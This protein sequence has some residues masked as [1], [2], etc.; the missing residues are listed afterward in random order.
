MFYAQ[1]GFPPK[2]GP[3]RV[4]SE[5][6]NFDLKNLI[7][8]NFPKKPVET[9]WQRKVDCIYQNYD[10]TSGLILVLLFFFTKLFFHFFQ[11]EIFLNFCIFGPTKWIFLTLVLIF[12]KF[13][14]YLTYKNWFWDHFSCFL[15]GASTQPF[16]PGTGPKSIFRCWYLKVKQVKSHVCIRRTHIIKKTARIELFVD[17]IFLSVWTKYTKNSP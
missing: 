2:S 13:G 16:G 15:A 6:P 3:F 10:F 17:T 1:F 11:S 12:S 7:T 8:E 14:M 5:C 4:H 9:D